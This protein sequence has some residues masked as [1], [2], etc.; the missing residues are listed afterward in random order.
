MALVVSNASYILKYV[1][2]SNYFLL[3]LCR[4]RENYTLV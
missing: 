2:L 4:V 1:T 3:G